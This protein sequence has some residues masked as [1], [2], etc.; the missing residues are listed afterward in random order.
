MGWKYSDIL[1]ATSWEYSSSGSDDTIANLQTTR[2]SSEIR[3][4]LV[5]F[6]R[7]GLFIIKRLVVYFYMY[8]F[9]FISLVIVF[10]YMHVQSQ[11]VGFTSSN[12]RLQSSIYIN[13]SESFVFI[14]NKTHD[15]SCN[16]LFSHLVTYSLLWLTYSP[17]YIHLVEHLLLWM[18]YSLFKKDIL[19]FLYSP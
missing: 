5:Y 8:T 2:Q 16:F 17:F 10:A 4:R 15:L 12:R 3:T 7:Y 19:V 18:I 11:T 1:V 13:S 14:T 6:S 9:L